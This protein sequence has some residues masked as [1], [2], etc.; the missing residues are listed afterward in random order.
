MGHGC[1]A[2]GWESFGIRERVSFEE[3]TRRARKVH[4][5]KYRYDEASY[6]RASAN[7]TVICPVHGPFRQNGSAH[8]GGS[9]CPACGRKRTGAKNILPF[10]EFT[11]RARKVH[12]EKYRYD[13]ASYR[14]VGA[15]LT[16]I[17]PVHGEFTQTGE[18][19]LAGRGCRACAC[20][21][22]RE[23]ATVKTTMPF[24]EFLR[25]ARK[26]HGEKYRYDEAS[27]RGSEAKVT[28]I[29]PVHGPFTQ[30]RKEH[31]AGRGCRAC[32][33]KFIASK[34]ILPFEEFLRRARKVHGEKYRYD[35]ASYTHSEAKL[36]IICPVH[37]P[38]SQRGAAHFHGQGCP[39]C[40][41]ERSIAARGSP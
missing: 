23:S 22:R 7:L 14:G 27:Y 5:E 25:R 6:T 21:C 20:A 17:C 32:S 29:C 4:G 16:V 38:F 9:G 8:L 40:G 15:K 39:A 3:F 10:E 1:R 19:H 41:R 11:R 24:E 33:Q 34:R 37:G 26:A 31:L 36:T 18:E 30:M 2:C 12:G 28:I 35:E 13:E